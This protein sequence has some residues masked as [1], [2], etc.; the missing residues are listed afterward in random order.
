MG[1]A[2]IYLTTSFRRS[3]YV[4]TIVNVVILVTLSEIVNIHIKLSY[5][6]KGQFVT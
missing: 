1:I 3:E 4:E 2:L 5:D 6:S